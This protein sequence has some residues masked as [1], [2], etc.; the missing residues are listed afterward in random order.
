MRRDG[1]SVLIP[2]DELRAGVATLAREIDRDYAT[3][4]VVIVCVLK[5]AAI[6]TADLLRVLRAEVHRVEFVRA[7]SY[8]SGTESSGDVRLAGTLDPGHVSGQ[9]VLIV[10]DIADTGYTCLAVKDYI[11]SLGPASLRYCTLLDKPERREVD[12]QYEYVGFTIPNRFVVGYGMDFDE[13]Y[14]GLPAIYYFP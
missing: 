7:S 14:R 13:R 11:R 4:G 3:T 10:D 2:E 6:F 5:G 1:L 12:V 8:G 9:H